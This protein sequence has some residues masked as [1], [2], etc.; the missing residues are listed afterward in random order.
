MWRRKFSD[1]CATQTLSNQFILRVPPSTLIII[2]FVTI[3]FSG[4]GIG[5]AGGFRPAV[6]E[7]RTAAAKLFAFFALIVAV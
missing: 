6:S 1:F 4:F 3:A 5:L 2:A 7:L